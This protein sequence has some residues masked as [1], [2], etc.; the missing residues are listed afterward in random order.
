M[1]LGIR[2]EG[3]TAVGIRLKILEGF[4]AFRVTGWFQIN[5]G[6]RGRNEMRKS[7]PQIESQATYR[8]SSKEILNGHKNMI[9][10]VPK[11][12]FLIY[13]FKDTT[14]LTVCLLINKY[15][16]SFVQTIYSIMRVQQP[17]MH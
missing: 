1:Q 16:Y 5:A 15:N 12:K 4:G 6:C 7:W 9:K 13:G 3:G 11:N 8:Q 17:G 2:R 14:Y 10:S